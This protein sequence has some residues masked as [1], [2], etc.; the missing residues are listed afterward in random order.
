MSIEVRRRVRQVA[1][2][3]PA[4]AA[5]A[6][7]PFIGI[8]SAHAVSADLRADLQ[9]VVVNNVAGSGTAYVSVRG[10]NL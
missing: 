1:L 7:L 2:G 8:G 4:L 5:V 10:T 6:V 3:V 9:P